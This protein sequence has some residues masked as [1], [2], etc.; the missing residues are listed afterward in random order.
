MSEAKLRFPSSPSGTATARFRYAAPC[1]LRPGLLLP[2]EARAASTV[3]S[4]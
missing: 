2:A 3:D 4:R 1:A